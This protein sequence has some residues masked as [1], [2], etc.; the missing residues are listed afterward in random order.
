LH[1][2]DAYARVIADW[3]GPESLRVAEQP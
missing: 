3:L 2:T 1:F